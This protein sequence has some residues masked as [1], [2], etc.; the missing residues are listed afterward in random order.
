MGV[1]RPPLSLTGCVWLPPE[2]P[3]SFTHSRV[4][5]SS[6]MADEQRKMPVIFFVC[7]CSLLSQHSQTGW[8]NEAFVLSSRLSVI[9]LCKWPFRQIPR[10]SY[11]STLSLSSPRCCLGVWERRIE[12]MPVL[13][14]LYCAYRSP[15][16]SVKMQMLTQQIW[17]GAQ[18]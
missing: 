13:L 3:L 4:T 18:D 16:E 9:P 2:L 12:L 14:T 10:F 7:S 1:L 5:K 11:I 17:G 15:G 6:Q 8:G